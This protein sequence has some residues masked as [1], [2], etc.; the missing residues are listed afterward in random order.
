MSGVC[1]AILGKAENPSSDDI[2]AD[3]IFS[4]NLT[5]LP[6]ADDARHSFLLQGVIEA[7]AK[8]EM[9]I[10]T[11]LRNWKKLRMLGGARRRIE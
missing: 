7:T 3:K 1:R 4:A 9:R 6:Q 2:G 5:A 10:G 8:P 11:D